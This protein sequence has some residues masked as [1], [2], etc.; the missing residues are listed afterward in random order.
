MQSDFM[1]KTLLLT[2]AVDGAERQ[3]LGLVHESF[4]GGT[5][6]LGEVSQGTEMEETAGIAK[7]TVVPNRTEV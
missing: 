5:G 3:T 7:T 4:I 2:L 6:A 1:G